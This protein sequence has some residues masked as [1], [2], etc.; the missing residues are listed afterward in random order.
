[1]FAMGCSA[2]QSPAP[3]PCRKEEVVASDF[4]DKYLLGVKLGRGAFAQVRSCSKV[5][6]D[7]L[8]HGE[9]AAAQTDRAVK[10]LDL[11]SKDDPEAESTQ[12]RNVASKEIS[13]WQAVGKNDNCLQLHDVFIN[14]SLCF[15]VMEKCDSGLLQALEALPEIN[16]HSFGNV[17]YQMLAGIAH[18]HSL[19]VIHRDVKPDNFLVG[20]ANGQ[21]V[22][23]GDFG[24]SA[25]LPKQG[26][27]PGVFGTAPFMCPEMLN[28]HWYN[29]KAD[30]WSFAVIAYVFLYGKFPYMPAK[31]CSK[32]MKQAIIDGKDPSFEPVQLSSSSPSTRKR[33]PECSLF[34]SSLLDRNPESRPS[35]K[36]A[37]E[38]PW[39]QKIAQGK[40]MCTDELPSL[41]PMLHHAKK[42]G[43][44]E[45]RDPSSSSH[46]DKLLSS[47][48]QSRHGSPLPTTQSPEAS[49]LKTHHA[50]KRPSQ[51]TRKDAKLNDEWEN[52]SNVSCKTSTTCGSSHGT[53]SS[54]THPMRSQ[55]WGTTQ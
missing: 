24:L 45:V 53:S 2:S 3:V 34:L 19:K 40:S 17:F 41:R 18:C 29:E 26:K 1:M 32:A 51:K 28:G 39:M 37:L 52:M 38:M 30:V 13:V 12:L 4:F 33:S 36:D 23:L 55:P 11:R 44:F 48:H 15:M 42:V 46:V 20:G 8:G 9:D 22:K 31:Q 54:S 35:A 16:E 21:T 10:I 50:Q 49:F 5:S 47:L 43:A 6:Q 25:V 7:S 14:D 27:V